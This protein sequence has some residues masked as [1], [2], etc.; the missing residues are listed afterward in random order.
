VYLVALIFLCPLLLF[1]FW[2]GSAQ[3]WLG[4]EGTDAQL[5][6]REVYAWVAGTL[7]GVLYTA[8]WLYKSVAHAWWNVDRIVWRFLTPHISGALAFALLTFLQSG[9]LGFFDQES[10]EGTRYIIAIAFLAGYFSD[11]AVGALSRV[12]GHVFGS[13]ETGSSR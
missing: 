8:K 13:D 7:G 5:L 3:D 10:L 6:K 9:L 2:R 11:N 1:L 4:V 12:A